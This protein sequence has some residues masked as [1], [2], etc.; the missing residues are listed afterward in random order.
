MQHIRCKLCYEVFSSRNQLFDHFLRAKHDFVNN[1]VSSQSAQDRTAA[2]I[3]SRSQLFNNDHEAYYQA[4][5]KAGVISQQD[6]ETARD[7]VFPTASSAIAPDKSG[8]CIK[9]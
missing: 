3:A 4:Q 8:S 6:W 7:Y 1:D 9:N 2:S 5:V